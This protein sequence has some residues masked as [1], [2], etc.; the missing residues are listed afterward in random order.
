MTDGGGVVGADGGGTSGLDAVLDELDGALRR[1]VDQ[2]PWADRSGNV[3]VRSVRPGIGVA[4]SWAPEVRVFYDVCRSISMADVDAGWFV[5]ELRDGPDSN[6][7][8]PRAIDGVG[9]CFALGSD[10]GGGW[11]VVVGDGRVL[12]LPPAT[13]IDGRYEPSAVTPP[14]EVARSVFAL[15]EVLRDRAV[16]AGHACG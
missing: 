7:F 4:P 16:G 10:G 6:S 12:R 3:V 9:E 2:V 5:H 11:L 1:V 14:S 8:V 13:L 15:V